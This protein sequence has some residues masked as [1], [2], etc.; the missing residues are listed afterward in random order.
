M[1]ILVAVGAVVLAAA[2]S[3]LVIAQPVGAEEKAGPD[4]T[5]DPARLEAT[6]RMLSEK[7]GPRD[8]N[9]PENLDRVAQFIADS[10]AARGTK[11]SRQPFDR[12][13]RT[14]QN[15]IARYG[16]AAGPTIVV[17]AHYDSAG[18]RPGADDNASGV[19]GL[20]ELGRLMGE[21]P[22]PM[23]V[24]LVAFTLEE[25]PV[26]G[27]HQMGSYHH[28]ASLAKDGV[29]VRAMLSLEMIGYFTDQPDSQHLPTALLAPL[30]PT[31]GD[32]IALVANLGQIALVRQVKRAMKAA[33]T[34]LP[35]HS[36]NAPTL[37]PGIDFSD[38]RSYWQHGYPAL[39]VTDTAFNRNPHYHTAADTPDT[40]DYRRMALVVEGVHAA[41]WA[42][43]K[44]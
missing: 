4:V 35:V 40:L 16:P 17:G 6:V 2:V 43:S 10:L 37:I 22:P 27:D 1:W 33:A 19:A 25:P 32:F 3:A 34:T 42:L 36:I 13:G 41:V 5:A 23:S 8:V 26:Y 21:H 31:K 9:H 15:V 18:P 11:V 30:Y 12:D 14:Y 24:E 38:H 7:L 28:A 29:K 39:M 44:P 20:I